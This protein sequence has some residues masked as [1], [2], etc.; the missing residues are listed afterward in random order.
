M[1]IDSGEPVECSLYTAYTK[2][3]HKLHEQIKHYINNEMT[4]INKV[5]INDI[6]QK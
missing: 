5:T 4:D 2:Q 6:D 1:L 3:I